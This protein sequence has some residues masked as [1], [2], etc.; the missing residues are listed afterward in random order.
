M[1]YSWA[2]CIGIAVSHERDHNY[3]QNVMPGVIVLYTL[4]ESV[5]AYH[6]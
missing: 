4:T 6:Y 1:V 2:D 3:M 5:V